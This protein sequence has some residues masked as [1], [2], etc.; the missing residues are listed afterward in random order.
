MYR[1]KERWTP[2]MDGMLLH[3]LNIDG[4]SYNEASAYMKSNGFDVTRNSCIGRARREKMDT[5]GKVKVGAAKADKKYVK[6]YVVP[7]YETEAPLQ[8]IPVELRDE[9]PEPVALFTSDNWPID[10][11][12]CRYIFDDPKRS[13]PFHICGHPTKSGSSFC[14]YHHGKIWVKPAPR[15]DSIKPFLLSRSR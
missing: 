4:L 7:V 11:D 14:P 13:K 9:Q 6:P 1:N 15:L 5:P 8:N 2:E 10:P 3:C 12:T